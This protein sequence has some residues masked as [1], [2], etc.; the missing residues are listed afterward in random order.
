MIDINNELYHIQSDVLGDE[1]LN[2]ISVAMR[3]VSS[4]LDADIASE[5]FVIENGRY[6][7]DI[8]EAI[9]DALQKLSRAT[10]TP[11]ASD[12][13]AGFTIPYNLGTVTSRCGETIIME[14]E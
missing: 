1:V 9:H 11:T 10:P 14:A 5:L 8:R 3:K 12:V 7:I 2:A 13:V 6:G 4:G